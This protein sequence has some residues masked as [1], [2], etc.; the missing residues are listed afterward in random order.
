MRDH[1]FGS[2]QT[3]QAIVQAQ[4]RTPERWPARPLLLEGEPAT[5]GSVR[6]F[7]DAVLAEV[8]KRN[9][10]DAFGELFKNGEGLSD[11]GNSDIPCEQWRAIVVKGNAAID[12]HRTA[13][14][15][16][17]AKVAKVEFNI[18]DTVEVTKGGF[19]GQQGIVMEID[20]GVEKYVEIGPVAKPDGIPGWLH[21]W[22]PTSSW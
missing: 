21:V 16:A 8:G 4:A 7:I 22:L 13:R 19:A 12:K 6:R 5:L 9:A 14:L 18:G 17:P 15:D 20:I 2:V 10:E 1:L 3:V 11:F